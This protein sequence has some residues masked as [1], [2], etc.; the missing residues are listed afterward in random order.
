MC[1]RQGCG[2]VHISWPFSTGGSYRRLVVFVGTDKDSVKRQRTMT[3]SFAEHASYSTSDFYDTAV[4][5]RTQ[6]RA[7]LA[8]R[9]YSIRS[10]PERHPARGTS[11][12]D[13]V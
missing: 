4:A 9:L 6:S 2:R 1:R 5:V 10:R 7:A 11:Q 12:P 8:S 13:D 3:A